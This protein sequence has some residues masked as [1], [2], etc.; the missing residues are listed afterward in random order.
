MTSRSFFMAQ[1]VGEE[2]A[3]RYQRPVGFIGE[4]QKSEVVPSLTGLPAKNPR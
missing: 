4:D 2:I 1:D 3:K